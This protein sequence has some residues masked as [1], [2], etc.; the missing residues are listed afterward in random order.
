MVSFGATFFFYAR[1]SAKFY[2]LKFY[3]ERFDKYKTIEL[4]NGF[5]I[6]VGEPQNLG[7]TLEENKCNFAVYAPYAK[8]LFLCLFDENEHEIAQIEMPGKTEGVWHILV[9]NIFTGQFYGFRVCGKVSPKDGLF[10]DKEKLLIDPY[11]KMLSRPFIWDEKLYQGDSQKLI[12]KSVVVDDSFDWQ[13]VKKPNIK[14]TDTILY[15][16][17]VKG[18]SKRNLDIQEQ[19]RGKYLGLVEDFSL[20]YLKKLGIT[21]VQILPI[22]S[23]TS[24]PHLN[25]KNLVNYWGYNSINFFAPDMRYANENAVNEFKT[26]VRELHRNNI[27]VIMDVVYNH[28]AEGGFGGPVI[29]FRGFDNQN[30]YLFAKNEDSS[31]D[32]TNYINNTGCG[33]SV[34]M[35]NP[36]NLKLILDSLRYF[37]TNMQVDGFRFDLAV[38]L[39]R[40][41]YDYHYYSSFLKAIYQDPIL[42]NTKLI[43]E[44]WDIGYGGY[45]LG[46]FPS[47][48][49]E[50]NDKYRD[51]LRS[52]WRGEP[53]SLSDFATR[54]LGSRDIFLKDKRSIFSSVNYV[55]YH[56]GFTLHDLVTYNEKHN[57][58]NCENNQ[59]GH[60]HNIS[61]NW[62]VEG[63]DANE[64][65]IELRTRLKRNMLASVLFS[66]GI[67]HL[68]GGDEIARTQQGNNNA[69]CQDN[70]ISWFDWTKTKEKENL[71][72]FTSKLIE[73]RK[74]SLLR[75]FTLSDDN[76]Y[77]S[78][79]KYNATWYNPD[80]KLMKEIDWQDPTNK[81]IGLDIHA[82][83]ITKKEQ[84]IFMI[85]NASR[86]PIAFEL[87]LLEKGL[88]WNLVFDT[89]FIEPF[90]DKELKKTSYISQSKTVI[91]FT[92]NFS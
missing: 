32:Y 8:N 65:I 36:F 68:L 56:D 83:K 89:S 30:F 34:S 67:P 75:D 61:C 15:E 21:A 74:N 53:N 6:S 81:V 37:A 48:W 88:A 77:K 20:N 87:P 25:D 38:S 86:Y 26:M 62:G 64:N 66:M 18:F 33:N 44:P 17:H 43:A 52:F 57:E 39:A 22:M 11:A 73:L 23:F 9:D 28:S 41:N 78:N 2:P 50:C 69:Y 45:R 19:N 7:A 12:P 59:D 42:R 70:F 92:R 51:T 55:C 10:F 76:F 40:E 47:N 31:L 1:F 82:L 4:D 71:Y 46:E 5:T 27:E 63:E 3:M 49:H 91:Y 60:N 79:I 84:R 80:G 24:E 72:N 16:L 14:V 13:G 58:E 85:F 90:C 54:L 35:D 29:S